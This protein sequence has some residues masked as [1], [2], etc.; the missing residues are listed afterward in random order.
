MIGILVLAIK[1]PN[2][3]LTEIV[4]QII[5]IRAVVRLAVPGFSGG[6]AVRLVWGPEGVRRELVGMV[7]AGNSTIVFI[8]PVAAI[9]QAMGLTVRLP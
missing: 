5:G 3:V 7:V 8:T 2:C 1:W 4:G 6:V 9:E